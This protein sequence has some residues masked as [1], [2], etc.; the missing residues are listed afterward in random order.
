V[1]R[2]VVFGG[3]GTFGAIV[4]RE[5]AALGHAVTVAGRRR[6]RAEAF[7]RGLGEGHSGVAADASD[8]ESCRRA[9]AGHAVAVCCAGPFS[10]LGDALL[11]ACVDAGAHYADIA[12]DR[13]YVA[14]GRSWEGRLR[15]AGRAAVFGCS[16]LP[17]LSSALALRARAAYADPPR[18]VRVTLFIGN[19]N[20]KGAAAVQSMAQQLGREVAAPQGRLTV[21]GEP[22]RVRLPPPFGERTVR[23]IETPD[24][25]LLP[26]LVGAAEVRVKVG[27]ELALTSRLFAVF[28]AFRVRPGR[29]S[30]SLLAA[31]GG[32]VR[33]AGTSG[34]AVQ[35]ELS[36]ADGRGSRAAA[37]STSGGQR[38]AV[39]PCVMAADALAGGAGTAAGARWPHEVVGADNLLAALERAGFT[40]V[41]EV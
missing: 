14:L 15:A 11:A 23:T 12:D 35:V 30:A 2:I 19:R 33:A 26:A 29:R 24:Y 25:D 31:A 39:L 28:S 6:E 8:R 13:A 4:C 27:F 21:F 36:W 22:E 17:G 34:G 7:A 1:S 20:P 40:V 10:G 18:S 5:L 3:Y 37:V 16:S 38:M 9:V 32:L 41:E